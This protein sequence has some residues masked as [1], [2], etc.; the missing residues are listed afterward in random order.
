MSVA[1][2]REAIFEIHC[3]CDSDNKDLLKNLIKFSLMLGK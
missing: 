1:Q 2:I 3:T